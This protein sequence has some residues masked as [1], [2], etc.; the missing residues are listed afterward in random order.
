MSAPID[1]TTGR[2]AEVHAETCT[3]PGFRYAA[4]I[5]RTAASEANGTAGRVVMI[6]KHSGCPARR[7]V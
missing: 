3:R 1:P 2:P 4:T 5:R 6:C 7:I